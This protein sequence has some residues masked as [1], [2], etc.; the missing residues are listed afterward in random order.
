MGSSVHHQGKRNRRR[1][2]VRSV[3]SGH[4]ALFPA[5]RTGAD[6]ECRASVTYSV[7]PQALGFLGFPGSRDGVDGLDWERAYAWLDSQ[8][9]LDAMAPDSP[10]DPDFWV[11]DEE[12]FVKG[13][14]ADWIA[15]PRSSR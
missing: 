11:W 9:G 6:R 4:P 10:L 5:A 3:S 12:H 8:P 2:E 15:K 13:D 7:Q 14:P 1:R